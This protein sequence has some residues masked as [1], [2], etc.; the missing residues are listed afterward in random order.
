M[1]LRIN[2]IRRHTRVSIAIVADT[3][4]IAKGQAHLELSVHN[5]KEVPASLIEDKHKKK[6]QKKCILVHCTHGHNRTGFTLIARL[7]IGKCW[8]EF[9]STKRSLW[10][11]K[12]IWKAIATNR[13]PSA[14]RFTYEPL[15]WVI[16]ACA[17]W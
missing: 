15:D 17:T 12:P 5:I 8:Q 16:A 7:E 3:P 2:N 6:N 1:L 11:S 9:K 14:A 10:R 13:M 4:L